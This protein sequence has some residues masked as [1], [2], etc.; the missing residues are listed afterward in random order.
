M[1]LRI[2][3]LCLDCEELHVENSC[4]VCASERY[5]FLSAWLPSEERRR[6]RRP[7]QR[8]EGRRPVAAFRN[9]LA[10]VFNDVEPE[11]PAD[12]PRTRA[13]DMM[14]Q[15]NFDETPQEKTRQQP[16]KPQPAKSNVR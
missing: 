8:S 14:P 1:Q 4:P 3:R 5:A 11:K 15:M 7:A 9:L 2:A 6:W 10:A 16:V 13:S 12:G